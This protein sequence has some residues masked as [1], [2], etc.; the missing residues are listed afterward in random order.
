MTVELPASPKPFVNREEEQA[1]A[2][3]AVRE[4]VQRGELV[5]LSLS[6]PPGVGK[7]ELAYRIGRNLHAEGDFPHVLCVDLDDYRGPDGWL[8]TG[9]VLTQL[10]ESLGVEPASVKGAFGARRR[11]YRAVTSQSRVVVVLDNA[12]YGSEV[13]DL[14]P[15]SA[16][17]VI[18]TSGRPLHDLDGGA[19]ED[20][21]V[22]PLAAGAARELLEG[23]VTDGRFAADPE[24]TEALLQLCEGSPSA[25]RIAACTVSRHGLRPLA[26]LLDEVQGVLDEKIAPVVEQVLDVGYAELSPQGAELYRLLSVHPGPTF[27]RDS[28][29]ALLAQGVDAC[30]AGLEELHA[31]GLADL[32][33]AFMEPGA[34]LRLSQAQR[35][36]AR[37]KSEAA[38][39]ERAR[40]Q[41]R[42]L[43]W[44]VRQWQRSDLLIAG[45]RL[46]V[47]PLAGETPGG[48]DVA[49][50]DPGTAG[51]DQERAARLRR[52]VRWQYEDRHV[53]FASVRLAHA[54]G[55]DA[56]SVALCECAWTYAQ[57]HPPKADLLDVFG[58][59][60]ESATRAGDVRGI[61]RMTCQLARWL[62]E[63]DIPAAEAE[64]HA[65]FAAARGLG[66][67]ELDTK[68][69]ASALEFLGMLEAKKGDRASAADL[70]TESR[71][72]HESIG[73]AYGV[74]LQ[75]YRLGQTMSQARK[76][77]EAE[78][79]LARAHA[80]AAALKRE[81]MTARTG[82]ALGQVLSEL[83]RTDEARRLFQESLDSARRRESEFDQARVHDAFAGL[84]ERAG[85]GAE[86]TRQ[87]ASA[88][89]LRQRNGL[90]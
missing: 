47:Q 6:G 16:G 26:R 5:V 62:W 75:N 60:R 13:A 24:A 69:R 58:L 23:I 81:R 3:A 7:S 63:S 55:A 9:D 32:R 45:D 56:A 22:R 85:D 54:L 38:E 14:L 72:L 50:A 66:H 39:G 82:F 49:F 44:E 1:R 41:R 71:A 53:M 76:F 68:L 46:R 37:R 20:L 86:A 65:A 4:G 43:D 40:A 90:L 61:V 57:D 77:D 64:M 73:N 80:S 34:R 17:A 36:H 87:R 19:R 18:V 83:G 70:Y 78:D 15:S 84:E 67:E 51:S 59:G 2:G 74:L 12:R 27:T 48:P 29:A 28:A 33:P 11:Q 88:A 35:A 21:P 79:L 8:D 52:L 25:L 42:F 31:E 30:E 89:A 10:L